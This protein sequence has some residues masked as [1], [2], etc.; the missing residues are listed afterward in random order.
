MKLE[1]NKRPVVASISVDETRDVYAIR[2]LLEPY[3]AQ[4][5]SYRFQTEPELKQ[6]LI[7]LQGRICELLND[8][9]SRQSDADLYT[10]YADL[11]HR[12]QL[13]LMPSEQIDVLGKVASL[14]NNYVFR[15]RIFSKQ[16]SENE[17][18]NRMRAVCAE[19][20]AIIKAVLDSDAPRIERAILDHL[21]HSEG[22]SLLVLGR[23]GSS[24]G[25]PK[26]DE[27]TDE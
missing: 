8:L 3:Y 23:R 19:H 2:R 1:R 5:L 18:R 17:R 4:R 21:T 25:T 20:A 7:L 26:A 15:L 13:F 10:T 12:I 14:V 11:D 22:R 16:A 27:E 9:D 24:G 6:D